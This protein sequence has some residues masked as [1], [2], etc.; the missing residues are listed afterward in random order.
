[1]REERLNKAYEL[2]KSVI[3]SKILVSAEDF[4][5]KNEISNYSKFDKSSK[6]L[7][8]EINNYNVV[9]DYIFKALEKIDNN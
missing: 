6:E 3:D 2:I 7:G 9:K 8:E 5:F 4:R 1:M